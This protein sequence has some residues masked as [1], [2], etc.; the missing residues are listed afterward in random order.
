MHKPISSCP[1]SRQGLLV[2]LDLGGG[3]EG[4]VCWKFIG[5]LPGKS[6]WDQPRG[7]V[8]L[9]THANAAASEHFWQLMKAPFLEAT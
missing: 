4:G 7:A 9:A 8:E 2:Q 1:D 3:G 6:L 5:I